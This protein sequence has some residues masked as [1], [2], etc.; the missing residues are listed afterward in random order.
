MPQG[1]GYNSTELEKW[2]SLV[3]E[4]CGEKLARVFKSFGPL[5]LERLQE[6]FNYQMSRLPDM[7]PDLASMARSMTLFEFWLLAYG[8]LTVQSR[9]HPELAC[10][11]VLCGEQWRPDQVRVAVDDGAP[12]SREGRSGT[13]ENGVCTYD[14]N[15]PQAS[16]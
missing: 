16:L 3:V 8:Q 5:L 11:G 2:T 10:H 12:C 13:C 7:D 4:R 9:A 14:R 6:N 15:A 1:V